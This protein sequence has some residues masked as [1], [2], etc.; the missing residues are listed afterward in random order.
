MPEFQFDTNPIDESEDVLGVF[1]GSRGQVGQQIVITNR[2]LLLGPIDTGIALAIDAYVLN[3][4][5]PQAGDLVKAI[6]AHYAPLKA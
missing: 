1:Y 3:K 4:G 6:L 5:V 2:R